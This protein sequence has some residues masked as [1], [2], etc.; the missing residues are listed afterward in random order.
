MHLVLPI[1]M[2]G[3][4]QA[5]AT[6]SATAAVRTDFLPTFERLD[7]IRCA[8]EMPAG[9]AADGPEL[10]AGR[11]A[12]RVLPA[13]PLGEAV[14]RPYRRGGLPGRVL[15]RRYFLGARAF[16]ELILTE[17]LRWAG[18][19]V[20]EPLAAVQE[21][22]VLGYQAALLTRRL[23]GARPL[24]SLLPDAGPDEAATHLRRAARAVRRLHEAGGWHADLNAGNLLL[25]PDPTEPAFLLDLDR[26]RLLPAPLPPL[27][28]RRNLARLRRSLG[29]LGLEAG[30][31][32]WPA[33]EEAYEA[34]YEAGVAAPASASWSS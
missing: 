31:S 15:R 14:L 17:R 5:R 7:L 20:V 21:R 16:H 30:L 23:P 9:S 25:R 10:S 32:A 13:G 29:K 33:F 2:R 11:G 19:P 3:A 28:A 1:W 4:Y 12:V 26:G 34:A 22:R 27:L 18:V 8:G 24:S 6:G